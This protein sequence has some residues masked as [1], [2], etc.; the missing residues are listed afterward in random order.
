MVLHQFWQCSFRLKNYFRKLYF[1]FWTTIMGQ[2][3]CR[4]Q[5]CFCGHFFPSPP[6][7]V[8]FP[9]GLNILVPPPIKN[10]EQKP[11]LTLEYTFN[12]ELFMWP[13]H[14]AIFSQMALLYTSISGQR[15]LRILNLSFN[16]CTQMADMYRNCETDCMVNFLAKHGKNA[17]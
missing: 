8:L 16:C 10:L 2:F 12:S 15:R 13:S 7:P 3:L 17:I 9:W 6:H 11:W 14:I 4:G 1:M 5:F